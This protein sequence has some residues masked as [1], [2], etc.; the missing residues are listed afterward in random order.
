[1]ATIATAA[2]FVGSC[3]LL[4]LGLFL[5]AGALRDLFRS[6]LLPVIGARAIAALGGTML[7]VVGAYSARLAVPL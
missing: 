4:G 3:L 6:R 1:M 5:I 7:V 2:Q